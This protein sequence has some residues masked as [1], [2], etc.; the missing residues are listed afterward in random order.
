MFERTQS[1]EMNGKN[2]ESIQQRIENIL[3]KDLMYST[4]KVK[5]G[6]SLTRI[7][8]FKEHSEEDTQKSN[9][10]TILQEPERSVYIQVKGQLVDEEVDKLWSELE[11]DLVPVVQIKKVELFLEKA[12]TSATIK[13]LSNYKEPDLT[14]K[15]DN[16]VHASYSS[17]ILASENSIERRRCPNCGDEGSIHE[18]SDKNIILMYNPRIYGKK[19]YCGR[20]SFEWR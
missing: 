2:F 19:K 11:K 9:R 13:S 17:N 8:Y 20:C 1:F 15:E 12:E 6:K 14:I 3:Q 10:I 4:N 18:V 5:I 7:N 16:S